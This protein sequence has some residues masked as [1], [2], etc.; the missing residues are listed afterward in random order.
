MGGLFPTL[1]SCMCV[2]ANLD[3]ERWFVVT[4]RDAQEMGGWK[5]ASAVP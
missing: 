3:H 4:V 2:E 1:G 5:L